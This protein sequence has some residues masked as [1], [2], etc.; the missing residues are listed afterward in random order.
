MTESNHPESNPAAPQSVPDA[1]LPSIQRIA[2]RHRRVRTPRPELGEETVEPSIQRIVEQIVTLLTR[3]DYA[4]VAALTDGRELDAAELRSQID[5]YRCT[6]VPLPS[7]WERDRDIVGTH[8][9]PPRVA[10]LKVD[11]ETLEE[12]WSQLALLMTLTER[13]P[14][15]WDVVI[16]DIRVP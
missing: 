15:A 10:I 6:L 9:G 14:N 1:G 11:L 12:G 4:A 13:E 16:D 8:S 2:W 7:G 5:E 3:R